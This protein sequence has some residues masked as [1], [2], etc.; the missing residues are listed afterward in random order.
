MHFK[1]RYKICICSVILGEV[2][3]G[4]FPSSLHF[5]PD[6]SLLPTFSGHFFLFTILYPPPPS[7]LSLGNLRDFEITIA[8]V[9]AGPRTRHTE[10]LERLRRGQNY[11]GL[12]F[13]F[14][15][16]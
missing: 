4:K 8:C 13:I 15:K 5:R 7:P 2:Q 1:R 3:E 10:G 9:A 6:I 14:R 12:S 11:K 16:S